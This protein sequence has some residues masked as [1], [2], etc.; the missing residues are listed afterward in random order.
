ME[1]LYRKVN[2]SE[3]L[4][5][6]EGYYFTNFGISRYF[7]DTPQDQAWWGNHV[8]FF[9]EPIEIPDPTAQLQADKAELLE[10]KKGYVQILQIVLDNPANNLSK[11]TIDL[12]GTL[13]RDLENTKKYKQ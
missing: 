10:R 1:T 12:I 11:S 3:R 2:V 7:Y 8:R 5:K 4:P 13:I 6:E 9:F